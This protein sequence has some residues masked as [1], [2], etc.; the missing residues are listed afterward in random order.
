MMKMKS[1]ITVLLIAASLTSNAQTTDNTGSLGESVYHD[2]GGSPF[3]L[4]DWADGVVRFSSG[5]IANQ[6][7]IKFNAVKNQ[8][9]LQFQGSS[10]VTESKVK[11]FVLYTSVG[12]NKDSMVFKKGY[13]NY[14]SANEETF[15]QVL[16]QGKA[17]L[18]KLHLKI[19]S[20][21]PQIA[22]KIVYRRVR[23]EPQYFLVHNKTMILLPQDK[24]LVAEKF[25]D[26]QSEIQKYISEQQMKFR[27]NTDFIKLV[28]Y[29][30]SLQ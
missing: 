17:D 29:Y 27:D 1:V 10:F 20:E 19:I 13:P 28:A 30:N 24:L 5:R 6:F 15:Y 11:E 8:I 4:V 7:K 3:V 2:V 26:H 25:P 14:E 23:D 18:V 22:T 21:E 12:G 9:N 16:V